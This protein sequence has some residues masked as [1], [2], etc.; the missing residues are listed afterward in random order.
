MLYKPAPAVN[1]F[2]E[3]VMH[4]HVRSSLYGVELRT[5]LTT[6]LCNFKMLV[7]VG[8]DYSNMY[9]KTRL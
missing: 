3:T 6:E 1:K 4:I 7:T 5:E 8:Q 9:S 2:S